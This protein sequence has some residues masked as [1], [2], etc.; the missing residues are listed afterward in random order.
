MG[1]G[2]NWELEEKPPQSPGPVLSEPSPSTATNRRTGTAGRGLNLSTRGKTEAQSRTWKTHVCYRGR[3]PVTW[4]C[5]HALLSV[6]DTKKDPLNSKH[7]ASTQY[8]VMTYME[9]ESKEEG[10]DIYGYMQTCMGFPV[11]SDGKETACSAG[12]PGSVPGSGRSPGEGNGSPLQ[13]SCLENPMDRG[14]W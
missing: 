1:Q 8:S 10:T 11:S 2:R 5:T 14:V 12:G 13:F 7:R 3:G 6:T 9:E 4:D